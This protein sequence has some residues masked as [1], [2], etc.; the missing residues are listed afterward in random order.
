MQF[1][2]R[3]RMPRKGYVTV[4]TLLL[5]GPDPIRDQAIA[6]SEAHFKKNPAKGSR[7]YEI[8]RPGEM[9]E[10]V[11]VAIATV[12]VGPEGTHA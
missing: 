12:T 7:V 4:A 8:V 10:D 2:L 5:T 11:S 9:T 1:D 6:A 3:T